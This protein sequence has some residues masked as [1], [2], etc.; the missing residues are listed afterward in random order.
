M[1]AVTPLEALEQIATLLERKRAGRY[2][3]E[4]FRRA[5]DAVRDRP[6]AELR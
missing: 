2:K 4:A 3:E 5:A 6:E 1:I